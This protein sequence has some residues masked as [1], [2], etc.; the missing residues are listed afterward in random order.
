MVCNLCQADEAES[1]AQSKK[2]S[3]AG[4]VRDP[5]HLFSLTE[6]LGV[7]LLDEDVDNGQ[8]LPVQVQVDSINKVFKVISFKSFAHSFSTAD[9]ERCFLDEHT[10]HN[11]RSPIRRPWPESCC[12]ASQASIDCFYY[13][14]M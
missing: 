3:A 6:P 12:L 4:N 11:C 14:K 13:N 9:C 7:R 8:V 5:A 10:L 1:H 2:T